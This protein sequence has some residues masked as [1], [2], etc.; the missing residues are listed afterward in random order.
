MS[1]EKSAILMLSFVILALVVCAPAAFAQATTNDVSF[2]GQPAAN[3]CNG[4]SISLTG[5]F[6][7]ET[8][9]S[10]NPNNTI[11]MSFN[12]TENATGIGTPSGAKYVLNDSEH[13]EVNSKTLA[14]EQ[15]FTTKMKLISQGSAPNMTLR[16]TTH[17]VVDGN[18]NVTVSTSG[19]Q[20]SCN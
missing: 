8:T 11:H 13:Q 14:Q 4:D 19:F 16:M 1:H 15:Y 10:T 2:T 5:T 7:S 18:G 3:T 9:F 6:H 20:T 12:S 17:L